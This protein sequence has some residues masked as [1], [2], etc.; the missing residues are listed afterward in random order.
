M[1]FPFQHISL[2]LLIANLYLAT[3]ER[4]SDSRNELKAEVAEH[5]FADA[6]HSHKSEVRSKGFRLTERDDAIRRQINDLLDRT[7]GDDIFWFWD[8]EHYKNREWFFGLVKMTEGSEIDALVNHMLNRHGMAPMMIAR[9][10]AK[11]GS[12]PAQK[13]LTQQPASTGGH[14]I[15]LNHNGASINITVGIAGSNQSRTVTVNG[16]PSG[17]S[18]SQNSSKEAY[19]EFVR[20][21]WIHPA[22]RE[23]KELL[24]LLSLEG[25]RHL[26][27]YDHEWSVLEG[28]QKQVP[29]CDRFNPVGCILQAG[30]SDATYSYLIGQQFGDEL[31]DS[32]LEDSDAIQ[33]FTYNKDNKESDFQTNFPKSWRCNFMRPEHTNF[34]MDSGEAD[35]RMP[36]IIK[37][38]DSFTMKGKYFWEAGGVSCIDLPMSEEQVRFVNKDMCGYTEQMGK[39]VLQYL[40]EK[41]EPQKKWFAENG[42]KYWM[43][44]QG[45]F[46]KMCQESNKIKSA[47]EGADYLVG[48]DQR[49][50]MWQSE[51]NAD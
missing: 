8:T 51:G 31:I 32:V 36:R 11:G 42:I 45:E 33:A 10:L 39:F 17:S 9:S 3:Q 13:V 50:A 14:K 34:R 16:G 27:S 46:Y 21:Q 18:G 38:G 41:R 22:V 29:N 4:A 25:L 6:G 40:A 24:S 37:A 23:L 44:E 26:H 15:T 48:R 19:E 2:T 47:T 20:R 30:Y 1:Y 35:F 49:V 12:P 43:G 28:E 7:Q 5:S